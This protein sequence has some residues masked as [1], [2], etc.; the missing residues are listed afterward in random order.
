MKVSVRTH[1]THKLMYYH[2][3]YNGK[4]QLLEQIDAKIQVV[5][6]T[7]TILKLCQGN[8]CDR[9]VSE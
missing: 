1:G 3:N 5:Y 4:S 2:I 9:M 8:V 7:L 6:L